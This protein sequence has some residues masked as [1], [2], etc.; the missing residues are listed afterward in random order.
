M[1]FNITP[2][3]M[4]CNKQ[5]LKLEHPE[6]LLELL[7]LWVLWWVGVVGVV[8]LISNCTTDGEPDN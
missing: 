7:V 1:S 3:T 6:T 5:P 2:R 4:F 8:G